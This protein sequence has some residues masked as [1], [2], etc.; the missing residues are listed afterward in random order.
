M[1]DEHIA[2]QQQE[3]DKEKKRKQELLRIEE[4]TKRKVAKELKG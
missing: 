3:L 2:F 4:E 1:R